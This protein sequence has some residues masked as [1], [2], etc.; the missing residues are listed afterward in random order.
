VLQPVRHRSNVSPCFCFDAPYD[1]IPL[2]VS[3]R[4]N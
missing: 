3:F 2:H 4:P 1:R